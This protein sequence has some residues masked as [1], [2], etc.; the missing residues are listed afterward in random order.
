MITAGNAWE[1][2]ARLKSPAK[3]SVP[4]ITLC[5]NIQGRENERGNLMPVWREKRPIKV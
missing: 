5:S 2:R 3:H 4:L 1:V